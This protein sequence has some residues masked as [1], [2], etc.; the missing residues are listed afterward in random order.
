MYFK[1]RVHK[2]VYKLCSQARFGNCKNSLSH[3]LQISGNIWMT[4]YISRYCIYKL[5]K[6]SL[7]RTLKYK[8]RITTTM[9]ATPSREKVILSAITKELSA[10][11][12]Y[13]V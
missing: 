3:T 9:I 10:G 7:I 11:G 13:T 8:S 4:K 2:P 5:E 6:T 1:L 12:T